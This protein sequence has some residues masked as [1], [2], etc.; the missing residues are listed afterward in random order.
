MA[1]LVVD[2]TVG[3]MQ[4]ISSLTYLEV[5]YLIYKYVKFSVV[6]DF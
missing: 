4:M 2:I 6:I 3:M 5:C 1:K